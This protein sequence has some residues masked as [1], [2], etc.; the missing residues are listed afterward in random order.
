MARRVAARNVLN[1]IESLVRENLPLPDNR[2]IWDWAADNIDFG[3]TQAFKGPYNIDNVPW[4]MDP[5]RALKDPRIRTVIFRGPP[6]ISG[7]TIMAQ[8]YLCWRIC[9]RPA[10]LAFNAF[11]NVKADRWADTRWKTMIGTDQIRAACKRIA[12]RMSENRHDT[13]KR[14]NI[15]K[16]GDFL[17]IQGAEVDANRESDSVEVQ[18]NDECQFWGEPWLSEMKSRTDAF[19]DT[20]KILNIGLGGTKGT[21]WS[22]QWLNSDRREWSHHCPTWIGGCDKLFQYRFNLRDPEGAT[23][24]FDKTKVLLKTDGTFDYTAFRP[25]IYVG[26]PHCGM[27]IDYDAEL[28]ARMNLESMRRGDGYVCTN[29][30]ADPK[31]IGFHI[32]AFAIGRQPWWEIVEPWIKA[33]MGRSVFEKELMHSFITHKLVED[34][35][36]LPRVNRKEIQFGDYTSADMEKPGAWPDEWIRLM[37]CDKQHGARGDIPHYWVVIRAFSK[38]GASRLVWCGRVNEDHQL[39]EL[40]LKYGVRDWSPEL[41]GPWVVIDRQH[42]PQE[43]DALCARFKWYGIMAQ[44]N[45]EKYQHPRGSM[46]APDEV[47]DHYFSE[48]REIDIG[49][50]S[51]TGERQIACYMLYVKQK[52]CDIL[53][54]LISGQ[55]DPWECPKD[56]YAFCPEYAD[57]IGS[58]HQVMESTKQGD[59]LLWRRIGHNADHL[60]SCEEQLVVLGL[61]AGVFKR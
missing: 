43:V 5:L 32:N 8:T 2:E 53:A 55:A 30:G 37:S 24:H 13:K 1:L 23:I 9:E 31:V 16:A 4:I 26:C 3:N 21:E 57:H 27:R 45:A 58:F 54:T 46:M 29:P 14:Q 50:G 59:K 25:T 48:I 35:D 38:T 22:N 19:S 60:R 20:Y 41:P 61:M 18:V 12:G 47:A 52:I 51:H 42:K 49:F 56:L 6:Q 17:I 7:K 15:F 39:R 36:D 28:L 33:T 34:W 44:E 40:Q 11:T 10:N